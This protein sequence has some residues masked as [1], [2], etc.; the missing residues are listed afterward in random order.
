MSENPKHRCT[1][2]DAPVSSGGES[3]QERPAVSLRVIG[4]IYSPARQPGDVQVAIDYILLSLPVLETRPKAPES[5]VPDGISSQR[6]QQALQP[7]GSGR[8]QY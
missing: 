5:T 1:T 7:P 3:C 6:W 2:R 4:V 8:R